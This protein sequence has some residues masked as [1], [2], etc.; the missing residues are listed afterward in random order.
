MIGC[1]LVFG[2]GL[3]SGY[4]FRNW[5][6]AAIL[7]PWFDGL[8]FS[9]AYLHALFSWADLGVL[10]V[11]SIVAATA[12]AN[13]GR[14]LT[15]YGSARLASAALAYEL[16]VPLAT[17]GLGWAGGMPHLWPDAFV[18]FCLHLGWAGLFCA[19][20][21]A[22]R[23]FRPLTLFGYTFGG[24]LGLVGVIFL[25]SVGSAGAIVGGQLALPTYT[26]SPTLTV[27][28]SPTLTATPSPTNTLTPTFPP[29]LTPTLTRTPTPPFT[30]TPTPVYAVIHVTV[31]DPPGATLRES[32]TFGSEMINVYLNNTLVQVLDTLEVEGRVW[33][34]VRVLQDG[35]EGWI[36]GMLL[37]ATTPEPNW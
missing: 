9:Q 12:L 7:E 4:A 28:P 2:M 34:H 23:G 14:N 10:F 20:A 37:L 26:P 16:Y 8:D 6:L 3:L 21:L 33:V 18:L 19:L 17:A 30:P 25:L 27:T 13:A 35:N 32:P 1:A 29:T 11:G 15:F 22:L 36:L 5:E 24:V 31:G